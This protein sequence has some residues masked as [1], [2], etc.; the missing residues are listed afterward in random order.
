MHAQIK[1]KLAGSH[2]GAINGNGNEHVVAIRGTLLS[3]S[4]AYRKAMDK[5]IVALESSDLEGSGYHEH[6]KVVD[7][8]IDHK[9][10]FMIACYG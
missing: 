8:Q 7:I 9:P 1:Q 5:C 4:R 6:L 3:A 2:T 10:F